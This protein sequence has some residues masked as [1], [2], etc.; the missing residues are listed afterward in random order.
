[1][2]QNSRTLRPGRTGSHTLLLCAGSRAHGRTHLHLEKA[3]DEAVAQASPEIRAVIEALQ[4]L[5]GVAQMTAATV[6]LRTG[7]PLPLSKPAA[8][9]G[10]QRPGVARTLQWKPDSTRCDHQDRQPSSQKS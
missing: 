6:V 8:V 2:D 9:D 3:I 1:M 10:L 5:R 7:Q 4:A